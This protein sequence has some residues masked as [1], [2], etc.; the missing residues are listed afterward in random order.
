MREYEKEEVE[1]DILP[2]LP[3]VKETGMSEVNIGLPRA[4]RC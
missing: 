4:E 3:P 2:V 1:F